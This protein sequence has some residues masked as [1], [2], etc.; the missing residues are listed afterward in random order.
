MNP[1]KH[2]KLLVNETDAMAPRLDDG[3]FTSAYACADVS[4]CWNR[5]SRMAYRNS[6]GVQ[7]RADEKPECGVLMGLI[8]TPEARMCIGS[9]HRRL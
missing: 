9:L 4:R 6:Q 7:N 2:P 5:R 3:H 1:A 8:Y